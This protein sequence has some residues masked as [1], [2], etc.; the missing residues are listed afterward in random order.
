M[1]KRKSGRRGS[2][3]Q[4]TDW[5]VSAQVRYVLRNRREGKCSCCPRRSWTGYRCL[6]CAREAA[7]AAQRRLKLGFGK[8][9]KVAR[10]GIPT[11]R[12][13]TPARLRFLKNNPPTP[14]PYQALPNYNM[15]LPPQYLEKLCVCGSLIRLQLQDSISPEDKLNVCRGVRFILCQTCGRS[16][17]IGRGVVKRAA[18]R[19]GVRFPMADP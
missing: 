17:G 3:D 11:W 10:A 9:G 8:G 4:F 19:Q 16:Q 13:P 1:T 2:A 14:E 5:P 7:I 18:K 15:T 6:R 12:E